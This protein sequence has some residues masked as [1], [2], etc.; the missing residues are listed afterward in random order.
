MAKD[1]LA[2]RLPTIAE[3]GSAFRSGD[4]KPSDVLEGCLARIAAWDG[5]LNAVITVTE[6]LA[7]EQAALADRELADG[8]ARGPLHGIPVGIKDIIDV[9]GVPTTW[10]SHALPPMTPPRSAVLVENLEAAG[11]VFVAKT[12]LLEFA[13]GALHP[14]FG[15]TN[16]PWDPTHISG[17]SSSGSGAG[18]TAGFFAGA[19]G[20]DTGGSIR[21]P[22]SYCGI[23]GLKPT[24][25]LVDVEGVYPLSSSL[26]H[27]GP[28]ARTPACALA[29]LGGMTGR[30][31]AITPVDLAG[32]RFAVIEDFRREPALQ[33]GVA[34][35]F[36]NAVSLLTAAGGRR[37]DVGM[38]DLGPCDQALIDIILPEST[39]VH[40]AILARHPEGYGPDTRHQLEMGFETTAM[41]YIKANAFR[42]ALT[43]QVDG[44]FDNVD[45]LVSPT[46]TWVAPGTDLLVLQDQGTIEMRFMVP[47]N[48]TG[49]PAL[50][51]PCGLAEHDLPAGLQ[52]IGPRG[53]D[54]RLLQ[55]AESW[56]RLMPLPAPP[57]LPG[58]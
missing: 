28:M 3:L 54:E 49:H 50:S 25:G 1:P 5:A 45:F 40:E 6:E 39:V 10:A 7:R 35:T 58:D 24:Y 21:A 46:V 43:G 52:L 12:N 38:P 48:L 32:L 4:L 56:S 23:A 51:I 19:V 34:E 16:N 8:I 29:I 2:S 17:G 41:A 30:D 26:D 13:S 47:W 31:F 15:Q 42:H 57:S 9:A 18:I 44:L 14:D 37:V 33:T 36:D 20:T 22:A 53:G 27:A 55:I 11:A